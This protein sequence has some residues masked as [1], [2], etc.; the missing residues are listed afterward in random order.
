MPNDEISVEPERLAAPQLRLL[1]RALIE[2]ARRTTKC[3]AEGNDPAIGA[4]GD[5]V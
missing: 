1:A 5:D 3:E 2:L 4:E